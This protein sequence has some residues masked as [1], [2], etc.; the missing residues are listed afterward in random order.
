MWHLALIC[1]LFMAC[2]GRAELQGVIQSFQ[3]F[4]NVP[5]IAV[6]CAPNLL[7]AVALEFPIVNMTMSLGVYTTSTKLCLKPIPSHSFDKDAELADKVEAVRQLLD[8]SND[9]HDV[10]AKAVI[11]VHTRADAHDMCTRLKVRLCL[12][13]LVS[14]AYLH[15]KSRY[16]LIA[17]TH[18]TCETLCSGILGTQ[19]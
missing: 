5:C 18:P 1:I 12:F 6:T 19:A 7:P 17:Q 2:S 11:F 10:P 4:A 13:S 14:F 15:C 8:Q 3:V 16:K 9:K